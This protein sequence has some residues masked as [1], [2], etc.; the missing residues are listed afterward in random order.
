MD[1]RKLPPLKCPSGPSLCSPDQN[2]L[3]ETLKLGGAASIDVNSVLK[4][5][6]E[7]VTF[8]L[9]PTLPLFELVASPATYVF[10]MDTDDQ[11]SG[12]VMLNTSPDVLLGIGSFKTA[13]EGE[14][15]LTPLAPSSGLGAQ[16]CQKAML[17]RLFFRH[18]AQNSTGPFMRFQ[19]PE[20]LKK[21][22][23]EANTLYLAKALFK[24]TY[25]IIDHALQDAAGP[26]PFDIPHVC[27]I[28]AGLA[29]LYSQTAKSPGPGSKG[30]KQG[31]TVSNGYMVEE[32]IDVL[33]NEF[34][35]FIHNSDPIPLPD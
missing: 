8:Y 16:P 33:D 27:F 29:L 23:H 24:L 32:L 19:V 25:N 14:L 17:K 6:V 20:E 12:L 4:Q 2:N 13:H 3:K 30:L 26:P 28:E 34:L 1:S 22:L 11:Y 31:D 21:L 7:Q 15:T 35:K 9:I 18:K 10:D 5:K